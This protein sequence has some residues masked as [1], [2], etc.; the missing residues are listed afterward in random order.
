M[1][2]RKLRRNWGHA[3]LAA[4]HALNITRGGRE[5]VRRIYRVLEWPVRLSLAVLAV[6][7][8]APAPAP[9]HDI[10]NQIVLNGFVKPQ[11]QK[12]HF[13]ARVP[14]IM[15]TGMD[16]PKKGPGYLVLDRIDEGLQRSIAATA[17]EIGL[18]ED[19]VALRHTKAV[20]RISLP[21]DRSFESYAAAL[22]SIEGP[23]LPDSEMVFWNQGYFDVH[24]E[25][26]IRSPD[27]DFA[28]EFQVAPGLSGRLKM[29]LRYLPPAGAVRAYEIHGGFG[30]LALDPRW[31]Q[32]VWSFVKL[33]F[34]HILDGID[35][36]LFLLCLIVPF[37]LRQFWKLAAV[38]TSFTVAHS[39]T[40][41]A[42]AL[43]LVPAGEWFPPLV[44]TLIAVSILYMALENIVA[45]LRDRGEERILRWRW[46]VT[47]A[48]GLVHGFGF[49]FALK[50]D[51]Q[52]A[53][54][55]LLVSLLSFNLGVELGQLLV[56]ALVLPATAVLFRTP[57]FRRLGIAILS[58]FIAHTAWHWMLERAPDLGYVDWPGFEREWTV[59]LIGLAALPVL[60]GGAA[61][62]TV[63]RLGVRRHIGQ[64]RPAE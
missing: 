49:S 22:A 37:G 4:D 8:F 7:V 41:I 12:L 11:G 64:R 36:L 33:G 60:L 39:I 61:W 62:L 18:F 2:Q 1:P 31:H 23:P 59:V 58:A 19:G 43:G 52:F 27:S 5:T 13:V 57:S 24:Y 25:F 6:L 17:R 40:L 63:R 16:L 42:S 28:L 44:E 56:L 54:D 15:L 34:S 14:L 55:H 32:A 30:R 35:H 51:L 46:L 3:R 53:G 29:I 26:P 9:A 20:A 47:G 48:F 38:V 45:M 10:P 50:Q 21:S